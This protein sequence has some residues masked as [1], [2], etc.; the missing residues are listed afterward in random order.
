MRYEHDRPSDEARHHG[1]VS[2]TI[3]SLAICVQYKPPLQVCCMY[4]HTVHL[5]RY[6]DGGRMEEQ[7]DVRPDTT[8]HPRRGEAGRREMGIVQCAERMGKLGFFARLISVRR[9]SGCQWR[10]RRGSGLGR[11]DRQAIGRQ[12]TMDDGMT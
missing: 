11:F 5:C 8:R 2:I 1:C 10:A 4:I 6:M 9:A 7:M 3:H 12:A